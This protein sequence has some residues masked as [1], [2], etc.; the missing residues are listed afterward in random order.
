[1]V[2]HLKAPLQAL[3]H[4]LIHEHSVAPPPPK[5]SGAEVLI[6]SGL[7]RPARA[8]EKFYYQLRRHSANGYQRPVDF[9]CFHQQ[10]HATMAV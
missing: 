8:R 3:Y 5:N 6:S 4:G 7:T 10:A 1:M 2:Q 9:E